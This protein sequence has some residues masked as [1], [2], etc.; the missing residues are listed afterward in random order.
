MRQRFNPATSLLA[1]RPDVA[2][3][4][5]LATAQQALLDLQSGNKVVSVSYA[6]GSGNRSVTYGPTDLPA[7]QNLIRT[8]QMQLGIISRGR[9]PIRVV[10]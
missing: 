8:L 4:E 6:Q 10:F 5:D 3:R 1:G 9:R 2:L 7:L